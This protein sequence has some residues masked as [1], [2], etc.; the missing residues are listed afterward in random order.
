MIFAS[1][2]FVA[3]VVW[4][5]T[6]KIKGK[7]SV[8][9]RG[10]RCPSCRCVCRLWL[11]LGCPPGVL[12]KKKRDLGAKRVHASADQK[13]PKVQTWRSEGTRFSSTAHS[14]LITDL[15]AS[16]DREIPSSTP[17]AFDFSPHKPEP[18]SLSP[19]AFFSIWRPKVDREESW[20]DLKTLRM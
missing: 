18:S 2:R 5:G 20:H 8:C 1:S 10:F 12:K 19:P 11:L 13:T 6:N 17:T 4:K 3:L 14:I 15:I 7:L 16:P 9:S